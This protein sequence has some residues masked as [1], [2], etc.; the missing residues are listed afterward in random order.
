MSE[1]EPVGPQPERQPPPPGQPP[2]AEPGQPPAVLAGQ[3]PAAA[4]VQPPA[5]APVQPPAA[6]PGQPPVSTAEGAA[7]GRRRGRLA[8][9]L[10]VVA[11]ALALLCLGGV[12]VAF[13]VYDRATQPDR[14]NPTVAVRNYLDATFVMQDPTRA[15]LVTC[16]DPKAI[17]EV[18]ELAADIRRREQQYH[19]AI[20]V[21]WDSL[22]AHTIGNASEVDGV[23]RLSASVSGYEQQEL[24]H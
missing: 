10:L 15:A 1:A 2:A 17:T 6:A 20:T 12:T 22:T 4:P 7:T 3:S 24:Q 11:G 8:T 14:S 16:G 23:I 18:Q 13:V 19:T 5:A 9:V 21:T